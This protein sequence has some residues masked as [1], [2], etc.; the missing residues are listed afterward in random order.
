MKEEQ[1]EQ[2]PIVV[3]SNNQAVTTS[4]EVARYFEKQHPHV[5]RTIRDII[6]ESKNGSVDREF[7]ELNFQPIE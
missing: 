2:Y 6:N 7:N 4:W 3:I 1:Q 5:L